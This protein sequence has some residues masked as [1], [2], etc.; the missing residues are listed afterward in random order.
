MV[1]IEYTGSYQETT[2]TTQNISHFSDVYDDTS[3]TTTNYTEVPRRQYRYWVTVSSNNTQTTG[4][5]IDIDDFEIPEEDEIIY[6][7]EVKTLLL[8]Q[9]LVIKFRCGVFY[10][11]RAPP[12]LLTMEKKMSD[13]FDHGLDALN[14]FLNGEEDDEFVDMEEDMTDEEYLKKW[15][16]VK[17]DRGQPCKHPKCLSH[18]SHPC[19]GC[20]RIAGN[21]VIYDSNLPLIKD[22]K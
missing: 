22:K 7:E 21:G 14:R 6:D 19:E 11:I 3:T 20:G 17:Y 8:Y 2:G 1:I 12:H 4:S 10:T 5:G 13:T 16:T 9:V 15:L 18:I